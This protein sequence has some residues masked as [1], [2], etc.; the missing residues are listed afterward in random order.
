MWHSD[1]SFKAIPPNIQPA[2]IIPA[3]EGD[4]EFADMRAQNALDEK[5]QRNA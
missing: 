3:T 2:K 1:S 4:T 5:T